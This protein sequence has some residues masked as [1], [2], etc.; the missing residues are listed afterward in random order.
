MGSDGSPAIDLDAYCQR[1][2]Y[3]GPREPT[4][5][6]LR[7]LH[8]LQPA[9]IP[10]EAFDVLLGKGVNLSPSAVDAKLIGARRGGYC[11]E[12]NSVFK[13]A[14]A[15]MGFAVEGLLARVLWG[16]APDAALRGRSHMALRVT[17]DGAPWLADVGFGGAV[18]SAPLRFDVTA[19]QATPNGDYRLVPVGREHRLD[20]ATDDGWAPM[21]LIGSEAQLDVDYEAPNWVTSTHP[22]SIF[23]STLMLGRTTP[24]A[25]YALM[26]RRL[27][28]RHRDGRVV[29]ESLDADRLER[30]ITDLFGLALDDG[31]RRVLAQ[32]PPDPA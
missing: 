13:R 29:R 25:R 24:D 11:F 26:N 9:A 5:D 7:A 17:I 12:Q 6:T 8:A 21:L 2:G 16:G 23:R 27:T 28:T 4:L 19:A 32:I 10:F 15:T 3:G 1:V 30:A 22:D 18:M 31:H 20:L 14:L